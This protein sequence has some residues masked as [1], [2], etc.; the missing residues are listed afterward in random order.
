[1]PPGNS[2]LRQ[3]ASRRRYTDDVKAQAVALAE[4]IGPAQ[5]ARRLD[6]SAKTLANWLAAARSGKPP[7]S[8]SRLPVSGIESELARLRAGN[9][10]L[11][12]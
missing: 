9:T 12:M 10:T 11:R 6:L 2:P 1:M 8:P 5:A 4:S 7:G 3:H